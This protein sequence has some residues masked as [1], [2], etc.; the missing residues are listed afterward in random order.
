[1]PAVIEPLVPDDPLEAI[2]LFL[3]HALTKCRM[4]PVP[5]SSRAALGGIAPNIPQRRQDRSPNEVALRDDRWHLHILPGRRS[6]PCLSPAG[7]PAR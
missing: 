6:R 4:S 1:M 2:D 5:H 7:P 3:P